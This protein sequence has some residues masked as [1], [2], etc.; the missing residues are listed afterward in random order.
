M[1]YIYLFNPKYV[2]LG[3]KITEH[4]SFDLTVLRRKMMA[5]ARKPLS[6]FEQVEI[7][8]AKLGN[9]AALYGVASLC[10]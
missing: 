5:L 8:K 3:G 4:E 1:N 7:V 10:R 6:S 2:V 9:D